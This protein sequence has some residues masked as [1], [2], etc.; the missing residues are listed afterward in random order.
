M[1]GNLHLADFG[2]CK[3]IPDH[4]Q[5]NYSFCG[6]PDY[7]APEMIC[8][9]GYN[10]TVDF[11]GLGVLIYELIVGNPPFQWEDEAQLFDRITN[12]E[13]YYPSSMSY[14]LRS[15]LAGLL[16]KDP[17]KR[18]G[19][20]HGLSEIVNHPWC[21]NIDFV[22]IASK[23]MKTPIVPEL[24]ENNFANEFFDQKVP[25]EADFIKRLN[26]QL[27]GGDDKTPSERNRQQTMFLKFANFSFYSNIEDPYEKFSDS[28]FC[29]DDDDT[30]PLQAAKSTDSLGPKDWKSVLSHDLLN[31]KTVNFFN[32]SSSYTHPLV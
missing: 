32:Y 16:E 10:F 14:M 13:V 22:K 27:S 9:T 30:I 28:I 18:L 24:Y 20:K 23:K 6:S 1:D 11:Y 5:L 12:E 15:F 17:T 21:G 26:S 3:L 4:N 25:D 2:L 8:K 29:T 19:A 7:L 31:S